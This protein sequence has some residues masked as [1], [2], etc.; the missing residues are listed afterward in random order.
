MN[1][2]KTFSDLRLINVNELIDKK[3]N[4]SY[5]SWASAV[6]LLLQEDPTATWEFKEP[7]SYGQ[8]MMVYCEVTA[9]GKTIKMHLPVMDNR[10]NAI[11]NPDARK[12]NDAMM[13]CLAKCIACFGI[14][15]YI[16]KGEDLPDGE[17][18]PKEPI[19]TFKPPV[20]QARHIT[21]KPSFDD[22]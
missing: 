22:I 16:Y 2:V 10:N 5:L 15:L 1:K 13:R 20:Q 14:G 11:I 9:L 12:I 7:K 6:D 21:K 17:D 18:A 4:L 19:Q 3:G 8:T